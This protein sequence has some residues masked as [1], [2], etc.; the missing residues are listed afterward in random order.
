MHRV[1]L[2]RTTAYLNS[3]F[4]TSNQLPASN[5]SL[6]H[7]SS[8][9]AGLPW[10]AFDHSIVAGHSGGTQEL[11][12]MPAS[13]FIQAVVKRT[14]SNLDRARMTHIPLAAVKRATRARAGVC[15]VNGR[16]AAKPRSPTLIDVD[17][18]TKDE[19]ITDLNLPGIVAVHK[20]NSTVVVMPT[21]FV[22]SNALMAT[23]QITP[24]KSSKFMAQYLVSRDLE[25]HY[26]PGD[27]TAVR[28]TATSNARTIVE[29]KTECACIL[30]IA[31]AMLR[32]QL[33]PEHAKYLL[34]DAVEDVPP[35]TPVQVCLGDVHL[36][37]PCRFITIDRP[38]LPPGWEGDGFGGR[39]LAAT[40][41]GC[42]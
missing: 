3:M 12:S 11:A 41:L 30:S 15:V 2:H 22:H 28:L 23:L 39:D 16:A 34:E 26:M 38:P 18:A 21:G 13:R 24:D 20:E 6:A 14:R 32:N 27:R 40:L 7:S 8:E 4:G 5:I 35:G 31:Y 1:S 33:R 9:I 29:G 19:C 37:H 25:G 36:L 10:T 42:A 17:T